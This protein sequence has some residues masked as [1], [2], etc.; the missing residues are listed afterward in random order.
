M[1]QPLLHYLTTH[2]KQAALSQD[3]VA[4]LLGCRSG[5]KVSRYEQGRRA[6]N[7][8]TA[9]TYAAIF[10]V[11]VRDLFPGL[12]QAAEIRA[13]GRKQALLK[14]LKKGGDDPVTAYKRA[15]LKA[16]LDGRTLREAKPDHGE[17][18]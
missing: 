11:P 3:E 14:R 8:R 15:W 4:F 7:L 6:P 18:T 5:T 1:A 12:Y 16:S 10:D 9:L 17:E 2:R 13:T